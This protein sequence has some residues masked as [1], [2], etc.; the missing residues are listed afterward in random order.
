[1]SN[2]STIELSIVYETWLGEL[3]MLGLDDWSPKGR[4]GCVG[5]RPLHFLVAGNRIDLSLNSDYHQRLARTSHVVTCIDSVE[6]RMERT[7]CQDRIRHLHPGT[8]RM[9]RV[10]PIPTDH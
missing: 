8:P 7:L 1:M 3:H 4:S 5:L 2:L 10:L 6:Q 9:M